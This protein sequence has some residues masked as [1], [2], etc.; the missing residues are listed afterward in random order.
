MTKY[1][2]KSQGPTLEGVGMCRVVPDVS[3]A[4]C[5]MRT[6]PSVPSQVLA[7]ERFF[8][9]FTP[10]GPSLCTQRPGCP[11]LLSC[12]PYGVFGDQR[13]WRRGLLWNVAGLLQF[14]CGFIH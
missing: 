3:N 6:H 5:G 14:C 10:G 13:R 9:T 12:H 8:E 2:R 1:P 4:D 7:G 11:G